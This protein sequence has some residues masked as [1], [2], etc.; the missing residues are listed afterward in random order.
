MTDAENQQFLA[1][2]F[3]G[4]LP[5]ELE[6]EYGREVWQKSGYNPIYLSIFVLVFV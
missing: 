1:K 4:E 6:E 2:L 5:S 3:K